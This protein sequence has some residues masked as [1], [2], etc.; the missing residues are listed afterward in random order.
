MA[1]FFFILWPALATAFAGYL[2]HVS[3]LMPRKHSVLLIGIGL[4]ILT[5]I[6]YWLSNLASTEVLGMAA[7]L[8]VGFLAACVALV[9]SLWMAI[10]L[11]DWSKAAGLVLGVIFPVAMFFSVQVGDK[12][13]PEN[14]TQQNGYA[15]AR[16][17]YQYHAMEGHYPNKLADIDSR[18]LAT[19][20]EAVT[21]Q[22]TGWLYESDGGNFTLGY[23]YEPEKMGAQ[24]C[25]L[26]SSNPKWNCDF[27]NW[28]P[29][30]EV[31]TPGQQ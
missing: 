17:L 21:T 14:L 13:S 9:L 12:Y 28:G 8:I 16:A 18:F 29:F 19:L 27:N 24:V 2:I 23:W 20:P 30:R 3:L 7:A 4:T 25:L 31:P 26:T 15:I 1:E 11:K 5:G 22:H 10:T 6:C